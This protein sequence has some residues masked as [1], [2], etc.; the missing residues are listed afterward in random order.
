[1]ATIAISTWN[2]RVS[3]VFD[4]ASRLLVIKAGAEGNDSRFETDIS[5]H[6]PSSKIMRLNELGVDVLICGAIS[7]QFA[8][9]VRNSG[10]ELI[11]WISGQVDDVFNAYLKGNLFDAKYLM[12]GHPDYGRRESGHGL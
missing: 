1:M 10:I 4:E 2:D 7:G 5:E 11:P 9:M 8:Y 12:P 3:P 6:F